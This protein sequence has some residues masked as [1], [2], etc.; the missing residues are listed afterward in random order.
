M[1][2]SKFTALFNL[3]EIV[4]HIRRFPCEIQL[5]P[6]THTGTI[7]FSCPFDL[8]KA[9]PK[10]R[11][12]R[13]RSQSK[14]EPSFVHPRSTH[15]CPVPLAGISRTFHHLLTSLTSPFR[16]GNRRWNQ[17]PGRQKLNRL[18][19]EKSFTSTSREME[20]YDSL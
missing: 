11:I 5:K 7:I 20:I 3:R 17:F 9:L 13:A 6:F 4:F 19:E 12:N 2:S 1:E 15:F 8:D 10:S 18:W 14:D 16:A